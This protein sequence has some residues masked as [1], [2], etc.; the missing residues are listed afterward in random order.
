M[1]L[2]TL[3]L[4]GTNGPVAD[5]LSALAAYLLAE[6][7]DV[8]ALQEVDDWAG[9]TQAHRLADAVG[10]PVVHHVRTGRGMRRGEGLAVL[11]AGAAEPVA[12]V[13]LPGARTDHPRAVQVVDVPAPGGTVRLANTHLAWRLDAGQQRAEQAAAIRDAL[14]AW[15]GPAVIAGDLNDVVGSRALDTLV[16]AGFV[17]AV[18]AAGAEDRP[19][20][21]RVNPYLWQPELAG[22]RVDHLLVRDLAVRDAAVVLTGKDAPVVSDHYGV[23][24]TLASP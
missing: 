11:A 18:T 10:Y 3:N 2:L 1:R 23:R 8:V 14:A 20:F 13:R 21:D 9:V 4:W 5:R 19:T 17:D 15:A 22:R 6:R 24:A 7:P 16:E 12:T